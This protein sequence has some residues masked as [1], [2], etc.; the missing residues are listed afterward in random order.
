MGYDTDFSGEFELDKQLTPEHK[1]YLDDFSNTR[2]M[3]RSTDKLRDY[4]EGSL[5]T[6]LEDEVRRN[7]GLLS[8]GIEG[9]YYVGSTEN[10]GQTKDEAIIDFNRPPTTQPG[11][12]CK[13]A[14]NHD[15][16][17]IIWT[18]EEKFY[19]YCEWIKYLINN[20]LEPWG[21]QVNGTVRWQG[22]DENDK[23]MIDIYDNIVVV[24][25]E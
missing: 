4:S 11:L 16:T 18:G 7:A 22:E 25:Q 17:T 23:G 8:P 3:G 21:Y 15:G 19:F 20:F 12:W 14:P 24:S 13:W 5:V 2:R 1:K 6:G 9:E 10:M